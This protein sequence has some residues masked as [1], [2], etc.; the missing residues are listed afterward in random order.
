M[1][2]MAA[3]ST[4][5]MPRPSRYAATD[6]TWVRSTFSPYCSVVP[7][8]LRSILRRAEP[9]STFIFLTIPEPSSPVRTLCAGL[10]IL[11]A[12]PA[13][14]QNDENPLPVFS[15][16]YSRKSMPSEIC[17]AMSNLRRSPSRMADVFNS[18]C[19]LPAS[20]RGFPSASVAPTAFSTRGRTRYWLGAHMRAPLM[21]ACTKSWPT[22]SASADLADVNPV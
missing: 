7:A 4:P 1:S 16:T 2:R 14:F 8:T 22:A 15:E 11:V 20:S 21:G 6:F 18:I 13:K 5:V 9:V 17:L 3:S 12:I 10:A 19:C